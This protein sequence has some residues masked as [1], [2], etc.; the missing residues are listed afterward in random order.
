MGLS[1]TSW[2]ILSLMIFIPIFGAIIISLIGGERKTVDKNSKM[3]ALWTSLVVL[4][5]SIF[6]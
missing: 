2:P 6:A 5:L 4:V 1:M 3:V